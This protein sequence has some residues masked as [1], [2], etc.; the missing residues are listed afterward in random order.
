MLALSLGSS[1]GIY[2]IRS[3]YSET[4]QKTEFSEFDQFL[5][6][7]NVP[8]FILTGKS[9]GSDYENDGQHLMNRGFMGLPLTPVQAYLHHHSRQHQLVMNSIRWV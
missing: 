4:L 9:L 5:F 2:F 7:L 1:L 3:L 6:R 8:V